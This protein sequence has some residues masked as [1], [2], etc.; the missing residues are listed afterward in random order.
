M[1]QVYR[2]AKITQE[3]GPSQ[4]EYA[5]EIGRVLGVYSES[6]SMRY[7]VH[8][9]LFHNVIDMLSNDE[10]RNYWMP[11]IE[12]MRIIGCFAMVS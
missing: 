9:S 10:Q 1:G 2:L 11:L 8:D 6:F 12:D 3:L 7:F 5:Q 4:K